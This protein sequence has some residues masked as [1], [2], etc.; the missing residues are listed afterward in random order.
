MSAGADLLAQWNYNST[1][2]NDYFVITLPDRGKWILSPIDNHYYTPS[3]GAGWYS[4]TS[5]ADRV[6]NAISFQ[7]NSSYGDLMPVIT[8]IDD[9]KGAALLTVQRDSL[10]DITS[11]SDRYNRS[12]Y[13]H[14][15]TYNTMNVGQLPSYQELDHVSQIVATG[16]ANPP[17][18]YVY[19]YTDVLNGEGNEEVPFLTGITVPS[20]TGNGTSTAKLSYLPYTDYVNTITD[21]NGNVTT[22]TQVDAN[23]TKV[24]VANAQGQVAYS[25]TVGYDNNMSATTT[26]N[27]S[28]QTV[29]QSDTYSDPNDPYKPSQIQNGDGVASGG[30]NGDGTCSYTWDQYGNALTATNSYGVTTKYSLNYTQFAL[31][32]LESIQIG[33]QTP[34]SYTYYEPSGLLKT[35]SEPMPGTTSSGQTVQ[36]SYTYDSLGNTLTATKPGN[37]AAT[38]ITTTYGYISDPAYNYS[39]TEGLGKPITVTNNLGNTSHLRYD[40]R[41]NCI[42]AIDA[43]GNEVDVTFNLADQKLETE[44][45][46]TIQSGARVYTEVNYIYTGG[47]ANAV[48]TFDSNGNPVQQ[49]QASYGLEGE[50]LTQSGNQQSKSNT[51]DALYRTTSLTDANGKT[52]HYTYNS[53]GYLA[54]VSFPLANGQY[55]T[56]QDVSYDDNGN[57]L[58]SIDGRGIETDYTY[59]DPENQLTDVTYPAY[60][61]YNQQITYDNYGR[62]ASIADYAGTR[63]FVYDD[64]DKPVMINTTYTGVPAQSISYSYY[65]NG[66]RESMTTPAGSFNYDY[67]ADGRLTSLMNPFNEQFNWQYLANSWVWSQQSGNAFK[68]VY[69]YNCQGECN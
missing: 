2:G 4:L 32:E 58:K 12:V 37:N 66:S 60:A 22:F 63:S 34:T 33:N 36:Y 3:D 39:T 21:G 28:N 19:G 5:I 6:G 20:P 43:L 42:T 11:I 7:Y 41:G 29:V 68:A 49:V 62:E 16:S 52:T 30:S 24:S 55:D 18:R 13:Y 27:G 67:D 46:S 54:T 50:T 31:G 65:P 61:A 8:E 35:V 26:T 45:P 69:G 48:T 38:S 40:A 44:Y 23:H 14:V 57:L 25:Y 10:G 59:N 47:P 64:L 9:S 17:D 15:G 1:T 51:Y 53:A 56:I